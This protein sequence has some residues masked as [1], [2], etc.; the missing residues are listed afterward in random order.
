M[1]TLIL[2]GIGAVIAY[3]ATCYVWPYTRCTRTRCESGKLRAPNGRTWRRCPRCGGSGSR[4][5]IGRR[6]LELL[7]APGLG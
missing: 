4:V 2:I 1:G 5:R 7:G 3:A 6:V